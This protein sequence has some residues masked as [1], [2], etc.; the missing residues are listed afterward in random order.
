MPQPGDR[1]MSTETLREREGWTSNRA[2][3]WQIEKRRLRSHKRTSKDV[4]T[5]MADNN[6]K[7]LD[8]NLKSQGIHANLLNKK[9]YEKKL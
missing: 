2:I 6:L 8:E 4:K 5:L 7:Y 1:K 3:Q 9:I